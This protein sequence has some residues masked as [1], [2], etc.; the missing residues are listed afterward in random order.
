MSWLD[1]CSARASGMQATLWGCRDLCDLEYLP[2][3]RKDPPAQL[4]WRQDRGREELGVD[5]T[6]CRTSAGTQLGSGMV[7]V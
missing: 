5:Y 4:R 2:K 3:L 1:T 7:G 6:L